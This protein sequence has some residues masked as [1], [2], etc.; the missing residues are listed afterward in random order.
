MESK[1]NVY[2]LKLE[3][4]K[5]YIGWTARENGERFIEHWNGSGSLWTK[6]YPPLS[7]P[8]AVLYFFPGTTED[9]DELT[10]NYMRIYGWWN[11]RGGRF[12]ETEMRYPPPE[13]IKLPKGIPW[14]ERIIY[15]IV[16][17]LG[18]S[19]TRRITAPQRVP[20]KREI[21]SVDNMPDLVL[22][23]KQDCL[24]GEIDEKQIPLLGKE[25][26]HETAW[27]LA[28]ANQRVKSI[29]PRTRV[30]TCERCGRNNHSSNGCYAKTHLNGNKID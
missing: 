12:I 21:L 29:L 20:I 17:L 16:S 2:A 19:D 1:G 26:K 8:N 14:Y 28:I 10:L 9:E 30:K 6:K 24:E 5:Y 23:E 25:E 4:G 3:G 13:L 27:S 22:D 11:V 18:K 7:F 15:C